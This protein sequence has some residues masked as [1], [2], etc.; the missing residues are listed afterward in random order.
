VSLYSLM[1]VNSTG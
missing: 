1:F